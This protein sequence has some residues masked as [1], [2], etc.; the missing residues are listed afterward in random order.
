MKV[1]ARDGRRAHV[2][3]TFLC[4]DSEFIRLQ[5]DMRRWGLLGL[6]ENEECRAVDRVVPR[7]CIRYHGTSAVTRHFLPPRARHNSSR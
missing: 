5:H 4:R 1:C 6:P 7:G 2:S 3:S